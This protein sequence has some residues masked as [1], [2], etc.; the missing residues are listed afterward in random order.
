MLSALS[1]MMLSWR[2]HPFALDATSLILLV[3]STVVAE[4][5]AVYL[6]GGGSASISY[7]LSIAALLLFGPTGGGLVAAFSG[8]TYADVRDRRS[9][10]IMLF[11][12]SQLAVSAVLSGLAVCNCGRRLP[13]LR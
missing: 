6:P 12:T 5:L 8:I 1:A 9:P 7:P 10:F 4:N 2:F 13:V 11:N 3:A